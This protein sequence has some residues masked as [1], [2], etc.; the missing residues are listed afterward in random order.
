[1]TCNY[2]GKVRCHHLGPD[3]EQHTNP[4]RQHAAVLPP[5]PGASTPLNLFA[6]GDRRE[7]VCLACSHVIP[8]GIDQAFLRARHGQWHV[9]RG[10]A[11]EDRRGLPEG[12]VRYTVVKR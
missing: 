9:R 4:N 3:D 11:V 12:A 10:E 5:T 2:C 1:M 8:N 6:L 7:L